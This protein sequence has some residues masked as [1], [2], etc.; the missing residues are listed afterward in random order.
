MRKLAKPVTQRGQSQPPKGLA[1]FIELANMKLDRPLDDASFVFHSEVRD[2]SKTVKLRD[3]WVWI[4]EET[5]STLPPEARA[6]P[7]KQI[8]RW[9]DPMQSERRGRSSNYSSSGFDSASVVDGEIDAGR[10]AANSA[11]TRARVC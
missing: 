6:H 10:L 3:F 8:C 9:K 4:C 11:M 1:R 2:S 7:V 5:A